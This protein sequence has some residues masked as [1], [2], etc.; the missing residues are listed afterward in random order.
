MSPES[1]RAWVL[2]LAA[3]NLTF[4]PEPLQWLE[5]FSL[6]PYF[7][8][9]ASLCPFDQVNPSPPNFLHS[10]ANALSLECPCKFNKNWFLDL[11]LS[12]QLTVL[13]SLLSCVVLDL[14][15]VEH[16][17]FLTLNTNPW[18]L[19]QDQFPTLYQNIWI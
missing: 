13:M 6:G 16:S 10:L 12:L 4:V 11:V 15:L 3:W 8:A 19:S 9:K 1:R 2:W 17:H 5:S 18:P 14:S 7:S